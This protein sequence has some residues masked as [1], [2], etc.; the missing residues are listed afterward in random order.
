MIALGAVVL[1]GAGLRAALLGNGLWGDEGYTYFDIT[2]PTLRDLYVHMITSE[3]NP[4][5]FFL[6]LRAWTHLFGLSELALKTFPLLWSV[7]AIPATYLFARVWTSRG[8]ALG[9]ALV[10]AASVQS[11]WFSTEVRPYAM[12]EFFV[13]LCAGFYCR[14]VFYNSSRALA[15]W[16]LCAVAAVYTQYTGLIL[17][18]ALA[19]TTLL[20]ARAVRIN[21]VRLAL[22]YALV[23]LAFAA[24]APSFVVQL[25]SGRPWTFGIPLTD[26]PGS[27]FETFGLY[28][29]RFHGRRGRSASPSMGCS[30]RTSS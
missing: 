2:A 26:R 13:P 5:L 20:F 17:L 9:A 28:F 29:R 27:V 10:V 16:V 4:P 6:V 21:W 12:V 24:W 11:I 30:P 15:A 1:V 23:G 3:G 19:L 25:H 8:V 7:A 14:A 22:A 18:G